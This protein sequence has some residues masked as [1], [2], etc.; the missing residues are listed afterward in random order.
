VPTDAET[1]RILAKMDHLTTVVEEQVDVIIANKGRFEQ[2]KVAGLVRRN[3]TKTGEVSVELE[4]V[5][6]EKAPAAL[7]PEAE[8]LTARRTAAF[9]KAQAAFAGATGGEDVAEGEE[10]D[11]D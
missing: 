10:D 3:L 1:K 8:K 7:K 9:A 5:M 2:L 6:L 11:S 4:K